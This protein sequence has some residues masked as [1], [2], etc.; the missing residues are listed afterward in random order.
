M[1]ATR[2]VIIVGAGPAGV[3]MAAALRQRGVNDVLVIDRY[4]VGASFLRWP[5]E[6][7]FITPSF[8]SNPFGPID[9][10]AVTSDSSPARTSGREHLDGAAYANYLTTVLAEY[11]IP[12]LAPC[13]VESVALLG[14]GG[15]RLTTSQ[16]VLESPL[17]I[18]AT[19]EFQFPDMAIFP[20]AEHCRHY[21]SMTSWKDPTCDSCIVIGGY[22][23][24]VDASVNLLHAGNKVIMLT[25]SAPWA[26]SH[27]EDPSISLSPYSRERLQNVTHHPHLAI[28]EDADVCAVEQTTDNSYVVH[29]T[30]G[31]HWKS[32]QSP[33]LATGFQCGGGARQLTALFDWNQHGFPCLTQ[34]DESTL[35]PG[36]YLAGPHVRHAQQIY[37]FI[38]KFRQ[39]FP[40]VARA[41]ARKLNLADENSDD[42]ELLPLPS[43]CCDDDAC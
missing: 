35:F 41:I 10:N 20:G 33:L 34:E 15:Y 43:T 31:R 25:R 16:G 6:T 7:R 38:Y 5:D 36:L 18:W 1:N 9:L 21:A 24:A 30:D 17:L 14:A 28:Y 12:L 39:R 4:E 26:S 22:E 23:S 19:G 32:R 29:T 42:D 13:N 37:C 8:Y 11:Q 3:G 40:I 2:D 27:I